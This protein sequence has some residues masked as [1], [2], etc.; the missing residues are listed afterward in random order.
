[1]FRRWWFVKLVLAI[2][3]VLSLIV[4]LITPAFAWTWSSATHPAGDVNI[5][6]SGSGGGL[7]LY[8]GFYYIPGAGHVDQPLGNGMWETPNTSAGDPPG[9]GFL[10]HVAYSTY[11]VQG[12]TW[13]DIG[14]IATGTDP[15]AAHVVVSQGWT[16]APVDAYST[17]NGDMPKNSQACVTGYSI[18]SEQH[19][20][21]RCGTLPYACTRSLQ[22]CE[23]DSSSGIA[24]NGDSG[25]LVWWYN[26]AG[27]VTILGWLT[28]RGTVQAPDGSYTQGY[29]QTPWTLDHFSWTSGESWAGGNGIAP[30]PP[31]N[32]GTG[33]FV[34]VTGCQSD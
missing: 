30:F 34:T 5:Y 9:S 4:A 19:G 1:M 31:G 25:G 3:T 8:H 6:G 18:Y 15:I 32:D 27:G 2:V 14:L 17:G 26:N 11:P 20:G 33:C 13:P 10:G 12:T 7:W 28:N 16:N 22:V 21:Y 23:V 29:F 24:A